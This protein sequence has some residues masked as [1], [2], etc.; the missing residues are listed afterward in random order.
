M[1]EHVI[2]VDFGTDSVRAVV[3]NARTGEEAGQAESAFR[4]WGEGL[5]CDPG[6]D[7]Y[8]QHPRDHIEALSDSLQDALEGCREVAASV[9]G[10]S[11]DTTGSTPGPVDRGGTALALL[12]EFDAEPD[13]M[14]VLWKDH[15]AVEEAAEINR[16]ARSRGGEDFTRYSGG[17]YSAEW[18]W[19][20]IL[21]VLRGSASVRGSAFSWVEHCDWVTALLTGVTDPLSMKRSRCAAGHKAMWNA[22]WG[23]LPSEEFLEGVDPVLA[24]LRGRLY[25]DTVTADRAAGTLSAEWAGRLGLPEGVAVASGAIDAHIGAVG[26]GIKPYVL[27]KV[28]GTST[29]DMLVAPASDLAGKAIGGICGQ[30]DGS[31]IPGMVGL[32]A[33]QSAFGDVF[34]WFR[35]LLAWPLE[36]AGERSDAILNALLAEAAELPPGPAGPLALDW[37]NGRRTPDAD[38]TLRGAVTGIGLGTTAPELFKALVEATAYGARS[39]NERFVSEGVRI[40][41]VIA[42]GG[43][44]RKA[45]F[46]MQTLADVLG[47]PVKVSASE[48]TCALG[49]A[50]FAAV[51]SGVYK[52][53]ESAQEAM[54]AGFDLEYEPRPELS[55]P[56]EEAY[57]DYLR[58]GAFAETQH[59]GQVT[60]LRFP[61]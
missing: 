11:A 34:A 15:T 57:R 25:S 6:S 22:G 14:F 61:D 38:Q 32:E 39:I 31:I 41:E 48:Q 47:V 21:H 36:R 5:Y 56:Y 7:M 50:M 26:A 1:D 12:P 58:L 24:G 60:L 17:A 16:A 18:F 44:P 10:I 42:L 20:K 23:G 43:I 29:C 49:A 19:S 3:V 13:A 45:P 51:A 55:G 8:R 53:V 30:V 4:R 59:R 52:D 33:G 9:R 35:D 54:G 40:E 27:M 28:I 37:L 46:V 2:G